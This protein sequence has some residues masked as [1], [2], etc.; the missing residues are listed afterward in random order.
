MYFIACIQPL[1]IFNK[2]RSTD[3]SPE[4]LHKTRG[5]CETASYAKPD[6]IVIDADDQKKR[7][8]GFHRLETPEGKQASSMLRMLASGG[9]GKLDKPSNV[10]MLPTA[11]LLLNFTRSILLR[12]FRHYF[13]L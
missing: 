1:L 3:T 12:W 4:V 13:D 2:I 10:E 8:E 7:M 6:V 11:E 9:S 5:V